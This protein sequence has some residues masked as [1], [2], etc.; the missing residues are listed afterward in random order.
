MKSK[1]STTP[2]EDYHGVP[3]GWSREEII[4]SHKSLGGNF[5]IT[6]PEATE[7][8]APTWLPNRYNWLQYRATLY[9]IAEGIKASDQACIELAIRYG[10]GN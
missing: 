5:S 10:F 3:E 2:L 4:A 9:K 1:S 8:G 6:P 7:P